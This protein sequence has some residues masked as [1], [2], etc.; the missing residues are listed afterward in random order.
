VK[1]PDGL[2]PYEREPF[3]VVLRAVLGALFGA[4]IGST[5]GNLFGAHG[6]LK[7]L[8]VVGGAAIMGYA[9]VAYADQFWTPLFRWYRGWWR[10]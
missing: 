10:E 4:G 7:F 8:A 3:A 1:P 6:I 9:S 5:F 2:E